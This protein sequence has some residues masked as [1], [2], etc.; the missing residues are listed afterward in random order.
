MEDEEESLKD[1]GYEGTKE[2]HISPAS[3]GF[4]DQIRRP[5]P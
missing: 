4:L 3:L 1:G 5:A 2:G